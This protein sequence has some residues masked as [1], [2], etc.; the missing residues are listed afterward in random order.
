MPVHRFVQ[1]MALSIS[2]YMRW[3]GGQIRKCIWGKGNTHESHWGL[4]L[5]VSVGS[6]RKLLHDPRRVLHKCATQCRILPH[7][8]IERNLSHISRFQENNRATHLDNVLSKELSPVTH[9]MTDLLTIRNRNGSR[10]L[11]S[12]LR[13]RWW[14]VFSYTG[15]EICELKAQLVVFIVAH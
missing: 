10:V 4:Y 13:F 14:T 3:I 6:M 9:I 8:L 2:F 15:A 7:K 11:R 5:T 12:Q 1:P